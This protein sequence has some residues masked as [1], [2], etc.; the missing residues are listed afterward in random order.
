MQI[1]IERQEITWRA[2][3]RA[4]PNHHYSTV[5]AHF[6]NSKCNLVSFILDLKVFKGPTTMGKAIYNY[7]PIIAEVSRIQHD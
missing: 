1:E 5:T 3:H 4:G 2:D 7:C 6:I